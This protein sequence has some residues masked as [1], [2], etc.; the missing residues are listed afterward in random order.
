MISVLPSTSLSDSIKTISNKAQSLSTIELINELRN[1]IKDHENEE[2][3][4]KEARYAEYFRMKKQETI[5][6]FRKYNIFNKDLISDNK[7]EDG[8][9]N[10][11]KFSNENDTKE[12]SYSF[13]LSQKAME[14]RY[15]RINYSD[16]FE[17]KENWI[18]Y[19]DFSKPLKFGDIIDT[20]GISH[21]GWRFVGENNTLFSAHLDIPDYEE[22][23]TVPIEITRMY[24][25]TIAIYQKEVNQENEN[26]D[27]TKNKKEIK[28][29]TKK[30]EEKFPAI[31]AYELPFWDITVKK[32]DVPKN[33]KF[34]FTYEYLYYVD[35]KWHMYVRS[36]DNP[37][38]KVEVKLKNEHVQL[39]FEDD[40]DISF[41]DIK[42]I[43]S[44]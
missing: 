6:H 15:D 3:K 38:E 2:K 39:Y 12:G 14:E 7:H 19:F 26:E 33:S 11:H 41:E 8:S 36:V 21:I 29:K 1:I 42:E 40:E 44:N 35:N 18:K 28:E 10:L 34:F 32:Y 23:T 9:A 24:M 22:G 4:K 43:Y 16:I 17:E 27:E 37:Y 30:Y 31:Y 5:N 25:D 20:G 13:R